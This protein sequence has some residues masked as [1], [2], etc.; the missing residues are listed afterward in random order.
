MEKDRFVPCV[1]PVDDLVHI[2]FGNRDKYFCKGS[3]LSCY[4]TE[5]CGKRGA[6]R[7]TEKP[8]KSENGKKKA[9]KKGQKTET[10]D[11]DVETSEDDKET[12]RSE[13]KTTKKKSSG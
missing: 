7:K 6:K 8:E 12:Q 4:L 10:K 13:V 3:H 2:S 5:M 9:N 11:E 1:S